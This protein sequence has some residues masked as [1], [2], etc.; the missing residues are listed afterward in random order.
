MKTGGKLRDQ[1]YEYLHKRLLSGEY[2]PGDVLNQKQIAEEFGTSMSPVREALQRLSDMG[3][4]QVLPR[5][6]YL[7]TSMS[8]SDL[9]E[10]AHVRA[11]LEGE[12]AWQATS[13]IT[14][15]EISE[16]KALQDEAEAGGNTIVTN[17]RFHMIVAHAAGNSLA[18]RM[19]AD[20]LDRSERTLRVDPR[21]AGDKSGPWHRKL[22]ESFEAKDREAARSWMRDHIID[23]RMIVEVSFPDSGHVSSDHLSR[24]S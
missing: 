7:V 21:M 1:V 14:V 11:L 16:L 20:L 10:L 9:I 22:I 24:E 13:R 12:A 3:Y 8:A 4:L 23:I 18:E 15:E 19:I 5:T 2:R 6:G 17:R